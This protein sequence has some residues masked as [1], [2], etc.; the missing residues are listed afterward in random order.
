M[1]IFFTSLKALGS[2]FESKF[3]DGD[4]EEAYLAHK[5]SVADYLN[6]IVC[7]ASLHSTRMQYITTK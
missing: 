5:K 1:T 7:L 2:T 3:R 6:C 4:I